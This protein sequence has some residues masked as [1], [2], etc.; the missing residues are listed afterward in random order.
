MG[1]AGSWVLKQT[2]TCTYSHRSGIVKEVPVNYKNK[3]RT[4]AAIVN[5][6]VF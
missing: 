5:L 4:K 6:S 3:R 1:V 2:S